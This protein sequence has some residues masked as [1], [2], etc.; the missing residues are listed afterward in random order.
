MD[1][2][3]AYYAPNRISLKFLYTKEMYSIAYK[4]LFHKIDNFFIRECRL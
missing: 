1:I 4:L 2:L 3:A